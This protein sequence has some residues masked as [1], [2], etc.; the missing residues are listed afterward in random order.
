MFDDL[1]KNQKEIVFHMIKFYTSP[2]DEYLDSKYG[3]SDFSIAKE[4]F[5]ENIEYFINKK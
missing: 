2:Q 1:T 4:Y 3:T 5:N